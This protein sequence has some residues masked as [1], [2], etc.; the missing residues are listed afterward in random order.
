MHQAHTRQ[1]TQQQ[2]TTVL[3]TRKFCLSGCRGHPNRARVLPN[4]ACSFYHS[5]SSGWEPMLWAP[6][7]CSKQWK[8]WTDLLIRSC[9][10]AE[11]PCPGSHDNYWCETQS[12]LYLSDKS[13]ISET[14]LAPL[15]VTF[16]LSSPDS[17]SI[18]GLVRDS[19]HKKVLDKW[20]RPTTIAGGRKR[21]HSKLLPSQTISL[22][23]TQ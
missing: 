7:Y 5:S 17:L 23:W 14:I 20:H 13:Q 3:P 4:G 1:G 16:I 18:V 6:W 22:H 15:N 19:T 9:H 2:N 8:T 21:N 12:Q 10:R 11:L